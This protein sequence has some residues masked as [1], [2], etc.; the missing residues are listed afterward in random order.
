MTDDHE[1]QLNRAVSLRG[2]P[3]RLV[4][5]AEGQDT[6]P[7]WAGDPAQPPITTDDLRL[8]ALSGSPSALVLHHDEQATATSV[9]SAVSVAKGG[10]RTFAAGT[11]F[12]QGFS[13]KQTFM[14]RPKPL[15]SVW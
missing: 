5:A 8:V 11:G 13:Q 14:T 3:D 10:N 9:R 15:I 4:V 1:L 6:V 2:Y 7:T 12:E